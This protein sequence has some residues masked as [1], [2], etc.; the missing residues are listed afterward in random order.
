MSKQNIAIVGL[1]K[2]GTTFLS[3]ILSKSKSVHLACVVETMD[4]PGKTQAAA[5][6]VKVAT[7]DE[8]IAMGQDVDVIFDLTGNPSVVKEL[9]HKISSSFNG[10]TVVASDIIGQ[11]V[12][13][14]IVD[15]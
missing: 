12:W 3:A 1:G 14:L 8:L 4:T 10:H 6:G 9:R 5:A 7:M 2:G 13:A 15:A 11:L